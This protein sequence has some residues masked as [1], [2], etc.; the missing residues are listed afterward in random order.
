MDMRSFHKGRK[1]RW[2]AAWVLPVPAAFLIVMAAAVI[3]MAAIMIATADAAQKAD[4][5]TENGVTVIRN[6]RTPFVGPSGKAATVSLVED[7]IIGN[8]TGREDYWFGFL[9]SLA[10]DASGRIYTLDPKDIRVRVFGPD[11]A[12]IRTFGRKGQGPGEFSGP[13]G[14]VAAPD[15]TIVVSDVLNSRI[16]YFTRKGAHLK[17]TLFGTYRIGGLVIDKHANLFITNYV[18]GEKQTLELLKLSPEMSLLTK[19]HSVSFDAKPRSLNS[20][21]PISNR[22]FHDLAGEDRL[23]WM[24]STDYEV[25]VMDASGK[26]LMKILKERDPQRITENDRQRYIKNSFPG[27]V[28][29]QLKFEFPEF[30][31]AASGFMADEKGRIYVRT[32]ESDGRGGVAMDVFDPAG[33]YIARL[34]VPEDEEAVSVRN[35]KLYCIVKNSASGNPLVKRY[36]LKWK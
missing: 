10:V 36:A 27:T 6:P 28:P 23:A 16:S 1:G 24:V 19:I 22:L 17:D 14:I 21:N 5:R 30:F 7:L 13:G 32:Y 12:L 9:N 15:G 35:D 8:D 20:W 33:L 26:T 18:R 31:P 2:P 4:V 11:G 3:M 29:P 25:Q 34:F